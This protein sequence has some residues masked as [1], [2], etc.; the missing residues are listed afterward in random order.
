MSMNT[1]EDYRNLK[2]SDAIKLYDSLVSSAKKASKCLDALENV[3]EAISLSIVNLGE[4]YVSSALKVRTFLDQKFGEEL[5][6]N[7]SS[8]F[9]YKPFNPIEE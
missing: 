1:L 5:M 8:L 2:S 3:H 6:D 7:A 4:K 9:L